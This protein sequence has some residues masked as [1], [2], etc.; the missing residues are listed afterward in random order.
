MP[1]TARPDA[2]YPEKLIVYCDSAEIEDNDTMK[3]GVQATTM[4]DVLKH[5]EGKEERRVHSRTSMYSPLLR[6]TNPDKQF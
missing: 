3:T 4:I 6:D 1:Q 2:I 5:C